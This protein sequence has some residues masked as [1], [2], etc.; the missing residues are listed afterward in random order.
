MADALDHWADSASDEPGHY[1][2]YGACSEVFGDEEEL[3]DY[4][5]KEHFYSGTCD[6]E[7]QDL[8]SIKLVCN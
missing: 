3:R 2:D 7:F 6:R 4:E 8:T 5:F 1:C